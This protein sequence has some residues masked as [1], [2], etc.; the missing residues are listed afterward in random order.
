M[1]NNKPIRQDTSLLATIFWHYFQRRPES[2]E[3]YMLLLENLKDMGI[4]L[5]D[6]Y[7]ETIKI[8]DNKK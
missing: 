1:N 6:I 3:E 5:V 2:N 7:N 8:R 4:F